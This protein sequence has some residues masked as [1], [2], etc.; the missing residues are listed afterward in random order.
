MPFYHYKGRLIYFRHWK[1]FIG[2][3]IPPPVIAE[4][5][6]ELEHYITTVSSVH[7]PISKQLP[8]GLIRK[9]VRSRMK[10]NQVK[11]DR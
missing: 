11:F 3:Y 6:K 8:V 10:K 7:L 4:H 1:A 9:L 2:I 5:K